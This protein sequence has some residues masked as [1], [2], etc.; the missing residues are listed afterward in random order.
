MGRDVQ[1]IEE[2][3]SRGLAPGNKYRLREFAY[4]T[5]N[6]NNPPVYSTKAKW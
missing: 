2:A 4:L 3:H 1:D 5:G 6:G